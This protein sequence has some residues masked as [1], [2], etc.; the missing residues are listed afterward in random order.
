MPVCPPPVATRPE[1]ATAP[2]PAEPWVLGQ[3]VGAALVVVLLVVG[4]ASTAPPAMA[5]APTASAAERADVVISRAATTDATD[6]ADAGAPSGYSSTDRYR[7]AEARA[8]RERAA[9]AER[10]EARQRRLRQERADRDLA[11]FVAA[12]A[13]QRKA[14]KKAQEAARLAGRL[15]GPALAADPTAPATMLTPGAP[16]AVAAVGTAWVKPLQ[17]A[18]RITARFGQAGRLWSKDHTGVDLASPTGTPVA[19]VGAGTVTHAGHA[20]AYGLKVEITHADGSETWYAHLSRLDVAEGA[21][22]QAG[23]PIGSVG[24]TGNVTGPH[25]HLEVHTAGGGAIDP[26]RALAAHGVVL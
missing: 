12:V 17:A 13:D 15:M 10:E 24:A 20:G 23:A 9:R 4:W 1:P 22:V 11:A 6:A 8:E 7:R 5:P 14:Q 21:V 18:Y 19:A 2:A 25:L 16:A 3:V 26:V